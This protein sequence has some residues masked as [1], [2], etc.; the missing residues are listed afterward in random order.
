METQ[1]FPEPKELKM[2]PSVFWDKDGI[3]LKGTTI[4]EKY[5]TAYLNKPKQ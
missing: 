4:T 5:Y 1:W 3:L 2:L